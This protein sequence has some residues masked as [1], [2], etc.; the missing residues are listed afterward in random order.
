MVAPTE[1]HFWHELD[2][3][4]QLPDRVLLRHSGQI[5]IPDVYA[6]FFIAGNPSGCSQVQQEVWRLLQGSASSTVVV[7]MQYADG[8]LERVFV[9]ERSGATGRQAASY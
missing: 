7:N 1:K 3:H 6:S 8:Y 4:G 2:G 5:S 9:Y